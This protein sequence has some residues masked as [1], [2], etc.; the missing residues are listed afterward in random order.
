MKYSIVKNDYP[1]SLDL[2]KQ[3]IDQLASDQEWVVDDQNPDYVFVIGGDGTFLKAV[4]QFNHLLEQIKFYPIKKGGIGFYTNRNL[5][6]SKDLKTNLNLDECQINKYPLLEVMI[7]EQ[8]FFI[9]NELKV[10]NDVLPQQF[11]IFV[12]NQK[13]EDF[14]GTGVVFATPSGSTG[15][16]KSINGAI[17]YP[18]TQE[19]FEMQEVA[20]VSTVLFN[21]INAPIIFSGQETIK[22]TQISSLKVNDALTVVGDARVIATTFATI[23]IKISAIKLKIITTN[24]I[25]RATLLKDIFVDN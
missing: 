11:S 2:A 1:E 6:D 25:N 16:L 12:N 15:Y 3:L 10:L 9:I 5:F 4:N 19:L 14:K 8:K 13:L 20:P 21:T 17:I 7:D 24:K 22:L 23:V 18:T